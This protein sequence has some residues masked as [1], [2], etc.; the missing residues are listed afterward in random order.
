MRSFVPDRFVVDLPA[1]DLL[2]AD[3]FAALDLLVDFSTEALVL[4]DFR[5]AAIGGIVGRGCDRSS[6]T[7]PDP[8][9]SLATWCS[10]S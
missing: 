1:V 8:T 3:F 7:H 2:L 5:G 6:G 4:V 10:I 9:D